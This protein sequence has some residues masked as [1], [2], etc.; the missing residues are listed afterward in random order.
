MRDASNQPARTTFNCQCCNLTVVTAVEGLFYN[1]QP[2]SPRRFCSPAC[3]QAAYRRRQAGTAETT[4][5]QHH[6]GRNR[7]LN[8]QQ[9]PTNNTISHPANQANNPPT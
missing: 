6:G 1:P 2:G 9:P 7:N 3:R 8:K 5:A 4:P